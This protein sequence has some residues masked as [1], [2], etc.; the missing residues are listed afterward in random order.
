V[1]DFTP[2]TVWS[3]PQSVESSAVAVGAAD[4]GAELQL[5]LVP[6]SEPIRHPATNV[7]GRHDDFQTPPEAVAHLLPYLPPGCTVWE[8]AAGHHQIVNALIRAGHSVIASDV[9]TGQDFF[10]WAPSEDWDVQV[11]NPPF[12]RKTDWIARN[13]HLGKPWALLLPLTCLEGQERQA[14]YARFGIELV[15]L[16]RRPEFT[17]PSGKVGG[18]WFACAWFCWGLNIG[19]ALTFSGYDAPTGQPSLALE[20]TG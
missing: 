12:S 4:G 10:A 13:Y 5:A 7:R 20:P 19:R 8:P 2:Y 18:S 9:K 17:T 1:S 15:C 14:L 3:P 11:T 16:P 6:F